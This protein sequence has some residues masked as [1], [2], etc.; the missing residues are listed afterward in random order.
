MTRRVVDLQESPGKAHQEHSRILSMRLSVLGR[1]V[2]L[3]PT[4]IT[5]EF[6][7]MCSFFLLRPKLSFLHV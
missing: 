6:V 7:D 1:T 2:S 5:G 3:D 4:R